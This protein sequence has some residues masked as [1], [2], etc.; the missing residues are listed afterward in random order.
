MPTSLVSPTSFRR[1]PKSSGKAALQWRN[2]QG[3]FPWAYV[4]RDDDCIF[5]AYRGVW[6]ILEP[7]HWINHDYH[8]WLERISVPHLHVVV[9]AHT[10]RVIEIANAP[11]GHIM[12][13]CYSDGVVPDCSSIWA[14]EPLYTCCATTPGFSCAII[15]LWYSTINP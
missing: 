2:T 1:H 5:N 12:N 11:L 4:F 8:P 6:D 10:H 9:Y 14:A 15:A 7:D 3:R 13:H